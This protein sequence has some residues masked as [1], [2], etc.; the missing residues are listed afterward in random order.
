ME[1]ASFR[2]GITTETSTGAPPISRRVVISVFIS[3]ARSTAKFNLRAGLDETGTTAVRRRTSACFLFCRHY[4]DGVFAA[5][6]RPQ[7]CLTHRARIP[8][9]RS[10]LRN[11]AATAICSRSWVCG[12]ALPPPW[13]IPL[14]REL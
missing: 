3:D 7:H 14:R 5:L 8:P 11:R 2:Q 10:L 9:V 12:S 1:L 13:A 6:P 4:D